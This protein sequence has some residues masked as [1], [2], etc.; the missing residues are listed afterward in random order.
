MDALTYCLNDRKYYGISIN[1][2]RRMHVEIAFQETYQIIALTISTI[3]FLIA[4]S[5]A[6][7]SGIK[8]NLT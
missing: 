7:T 6:L 2:E 5:H 1:I 8:T 4:S 3:L